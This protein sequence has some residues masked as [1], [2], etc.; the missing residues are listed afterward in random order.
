MT[1]PLFQAIRGLDE[2][3]S[4]LSLH[5][6]DHLA[7]SSDIAPPIGV[8]TTFRFPNPDASKNG[9]GPNGEKLN[10]YSRE[11]TN[12]RDRAEAVLGALNEGIPAYLKLY[13]SGETKIV[14]I[15]L[16]QAYIVNTFVKHLCVGHAVTYASGLSAG[17]AAI[18]H[19]KPNRVAIRTGYHGT[20][21]FLKV[22]R[23]HREIVC[24][25]SI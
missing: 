10:I 3:F 1:T 12:T 6:D 4:S 22:Y 19:F 13:I 8:S 24:L 18:I 5:A 2:S 16:M 21:G 7:E 17:F 23:R 20:H 25:I 15:M 9:E 14:I 11:S